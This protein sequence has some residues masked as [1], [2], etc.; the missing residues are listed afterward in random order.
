MKYVWYPLRKE[1]PY[2]NLVVSLDKRMGL[3]S[4]SGDKTPD[5]CVSHGNMALLHD[6]GYFEV[7]ISSRMYPQT[8]IL[9]P[10]TFYIFLGGVEDNPDAWKV[11]IPIRAPSIK[12]FIDSMN[13]YFR[14]IELNKNIVI[15]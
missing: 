9:Y 15:L 13:H 2:L 1:H 10:N 14:N 11:N 4:V 7:D 8:N 12:L 3:V 6:K 5:F